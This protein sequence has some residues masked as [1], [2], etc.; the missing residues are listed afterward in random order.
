LRGHAQ[1]VHSVRFDRAGQRLVTTSI[2]RTVRVWDNASGRLVVTMLGH[3]RPTIQASFLPDA[4]DAG[5]KI[6]SVDSASR[7]RTWGTEADGPMRCASLLHCKDY[8]RQLDFVPGGARLRAAG[9]NSVIDIDLRV[10]RAES[11][12]RPLDGMSTSI[13][14]GTD[15]VLRSLD[16]RRLL[17]ESISSGDVKWSRDFEAYVDTVPSPD[18]KLFALMIDDGRIAIIR[19]DDASEIGVLRCDDAVGNLPVFSATGE[20]LLVPYANGAVR[21]WNISTCTLLSELVPAGEHGHGATFSPDGTLFAYGHALEGVTVCD[22]GTQIPITRIDG[23]GGQVWSI[24]IS[25]D[26]TRLA[27]GCQDRITHLY[28]LPS[29]DELLQLRDHTGSVMSLAWSP[30]GRILATGGYDKRVFVY[31]CKSLPGPAK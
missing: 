1:R 27:V 7:V 3:E 16:S 8:V 26:K 24:A 13:V 12:D 20:L 29:G 22:A 30:D 11:N 15:S 28:E 23:I 31:D 9:C 6:I 5:E 4:G 18:G 21:L 14:P 2:D 10:L 25:P 17:L 19:T